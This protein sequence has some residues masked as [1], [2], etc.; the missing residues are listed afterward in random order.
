FTEYDMDPAENKELKAELTAYKGYLEEDGIPNMVAD[1]L[2]S[3]IT[4]GQKYLRLNSVQPGAASGSSIVGT[5]ILER[6]AVRIEKRLTEAALEVIAGKVS[7][8]QDDLKAAR[9][10]LYDMREDQRAVG[11]ELRD[12]AARQ[13]DLAAR[14]AAAVDAA[15]SSFEKAKAEYREATMASAAMPA[16]QGNIF[17][18]MVLNWADTGI[19]SHKPTTARFDYMFVYDPTIVPAVHDFQEKCKSCQA[20]AGFVAPP[21]SALRGTGEERFT[22]HIIVELGP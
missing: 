6:K 21:T 2:R 14:Q 10:E 18:P 12:L 15:R 16:R 1:A 5:D 8:A 3:V 11:N 17:E 7:K 9:K 20:V 19:S 4:C 13:A 22:Q